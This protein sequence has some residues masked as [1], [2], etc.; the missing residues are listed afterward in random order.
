MTARS[1]FSLLALVLALA[2]SA[3]ARAAD[4]KVDGIWKSTFK[5]QDGTERTTTFKLK[6][7]GDKVTG[8]VSGRNNTEIAIENGTFKDGTVSFSVTRENDGKKFTSKYSGK[9]DGDIIKGNSE[10]PGRDGGEAVKRDW[11]AKRDK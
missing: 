8:T 3:P 10:R 4:A 11:E 1:I 2:F 7:E 9:L 6:V 5:A